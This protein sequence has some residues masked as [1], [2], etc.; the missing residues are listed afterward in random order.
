MLLNMNEK[1]ITPP[2]FTPGEDEIK[3]IGGSDPGLDGDIYVLPTD[4]RLPVA[5][6]GLLALVEEWDQTTFYVTEL[7]GVPVSTAAPLFA[8]AL[9]LY[10]IR[11]PKSY[12]TYLQP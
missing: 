12:L 8:P 4:A 6:A 3:V 10:N 11:L 5:V 7:E 2:D 1:M 9:S